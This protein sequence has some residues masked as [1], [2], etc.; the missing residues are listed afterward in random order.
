MANNDAPF[1]F[2]PVRHLTGGEIRPSVFS[3]AVADGDTNALY[4]GQPVKWGTTG[5]IV[6]AAP[7]DTN[8]LGVFMGC[9]YEDSANTNGVVFKPYFP[10]SATAKN[11]EFNVVTDPEVVFLVQAASASNADRGKYADFVVGTGNTVTGDAGSTIGATGAT[12]ANCLVLGMWTD[13]TNEDGA[14]AKVEV[15]FAEHVLR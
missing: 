13:P 5:N 6:A 10:G 11:I 2:R 7:G 9:Q 1:G 8:I 12:K 15:V 4:T 3:K 14:Y